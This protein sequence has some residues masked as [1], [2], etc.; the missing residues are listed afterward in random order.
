M[1]QTRNSENNNP[2]EPIA[3]QL[4]AIAAK[5]EVF[6]TMKEDIEALKEGERSR[7]RSGRNGEGE[8][9]WRSRK[10]R[11]PS[12]LADESRKILQTVI[13]WE[14]LVQAFTRSFG[15]AEFQNPDEFLCS[16]KQTGSEFAKRSSRVS[17]WPGHCL[18][19]VFL[20]GLKDELKSDV[21]IHKPHTV[22]SAMSL[23][24]EF[25][26]K[27]ATHRHGKNVSWTPNSKS[28]QPDPKPTFTPIPTSSQPKYTPRIPDTE[29]QNR[30]LK[31]ECFR[32]GNKYGP[33]HRCKTGTLKVLEAEEDME[34]PPVTQFF[35]PILTKRK[36][37]KSVCHAILAKPHPTTMKVRDNLHST[38]VLILID[39]GSTHNFISD[40][41]VNELKLT[42][43]PMAPFGVQIGNGDIIRCSNICKN[44]L[45]QVNELKIT[46]DFHPFS[47]GAADLV[48]GIQLLATLNTVQ[49]NWKE[50][51]MVFEI[52]GKQYK[53]QGVVSGPQKSSP[54]NIRPYRYP[55]SQK[56]EIEKQVKQLMAAGFIQPSTSPFSSPVLLVKK[57]NTWRMCVDYQALNKITIADKYLIPNI[58]ELLDGSFSSPPVIPLPI[59]KDW[60]IDLQPNS[61]ITHRWV[62]EAGQPVLEL[63]IAWCNRPVEEATWETYDLVAEQFPEFR[64]E[65]KAFYREGS[66]DKEEKTVW[67]LANPLG[68]NN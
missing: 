33:G 21:R 45:V 4:A 57:D 47:L 26:S 51:F 59:T 22:Y 58:D 13:F 20:N 25:E 62:Y 32:C 9:S 5:L 31:G 28:F 34:E 19:G 46:Q 17:N 37:L 66:N 52:D 54:P 10:Q 8:S 7:S 41:L 64:L 67:E 12:R 44:L 11:R 15:L 24:L 14:E 40:V 16:I 3:T 48:L 50:M 68:Q 55:H 39:G 36:R 61:V 43:K 1:V 27:L 56:A 38:E 30:F 42:S 49:A 2:P 35:N 29:K 63:L 23:A 53:L 6:E 65:D 18:L 60:E